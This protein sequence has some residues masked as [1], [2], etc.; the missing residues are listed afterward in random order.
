MYKNRLLITEDEKKYILSM[1]G[2]I[3]EQKLDINSSDFFDP[4]Y[5]SKLSTQGT[6]NLTIELG[7]ALDFIRKNEGKTTS[8]KILASEDKNQNYDNEVSPSKKIPTRQLAILR[9][10]TIKKFLTNFFQNAINE[11]YIKTIPTFEEPEIIVGKGTTAEEQKY[12]RRVEI[13]FSVISEPKTPPEIPPCA[14]NMKIRV[15][16]KEDVHGGHNCNSAVFEVSVNGIP[17]KRDGDG[18]KYASLNNA[19]VM[20]NA[21]YSI[22]DKKIAV[23]NAKGKVEYETK[24]Y[25]LSN[26]PGGPRENLF[27]IDDITMKAIQDANNELSIQLTC[28]NL[29]SYYPTP[30]DLLNVYPK[31]TDLTQWFTTNKP[32]LGGIEYNGTQFTYIENSEYKWFHSAQWGYKCHR[33]VGGIEFTNETGETSSFN[34]ATPEEVD[35]PK[36]VLTIN[37]CTLKVV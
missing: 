21:G 29:V 18:A 8:V 7:K 37:A 34:V 16:Y 4:G 30:T 14:K 2:L 36:L 11:G 33:G 10:E 13:S 15:F 6:K 3:K 12:D 26:N 32:N 20:D 9:A 1:Y 17:L 24:K 35:E 27:T 19:S 23:R 28:K 22:Q 31:I 5:H 25:P